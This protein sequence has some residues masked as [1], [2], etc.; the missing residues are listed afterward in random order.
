MFIGCLGEDRFY[1]ITEIIYLREQVIR[2]VEKVNILNFKISKIAE[3]IEK[4]QTYISIHIL[5]ELEVLEERIKE[6]SRKDDQ[7]F[8]KYKQLKDYSER[9]KI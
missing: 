7:F 4:N 5:N 3:R 6:I 1:L 2:W 8:K 9:L